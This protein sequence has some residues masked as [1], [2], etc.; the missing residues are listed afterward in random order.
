MTDGPVAGAATTLTLSSGDATLSLSNW[1]GSLTIDA[2]SQR[3]LSFNS[4]TTSGSGAQIALTGSA[5]IRG[6]LR[7]SSGTLTATTALVASDDLTI[8]PNGG[9]STLSLGTNALSVSQTSKTL[10][11]GDGSALLTVSA[12]SPAATLSSAGSGSLIFNSVNFQAIVN[13]GFT[14]VSTNGPPHPATISSVAASPS[15]RSI[16]RTL[17]A[18]TLCPPPRLSTRMFVSFERDQHVRSG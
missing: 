18:C 8:N 12:S 13:S 16:A 14:A 2:P 9:T 7:I 5:Q 1:A 6:T 11:L 3:F 17:I 4:A 10:R 15:L